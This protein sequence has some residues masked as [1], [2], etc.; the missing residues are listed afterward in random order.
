MGDD[1]R[2]RL[3]TPFHLAELRVDPAS[4]RIVGP[5][6][7]R[8]LEPRVMDVLVA[9]AARAPE[10]V[11]RA[12]LIDSVWG[13]AIV[14]DSVLSR[15][16]S[17]LREQLGDD[18]AEPRFIETLSK[19]GYRLLAPVS[20]VGAGPPAGLMAEAFARS[21]ADPVGGAAPAVAI[22]VLPFVNLAADAADEHLADGLTELMIANLAGIAS[23]RVIA[24]TSSMVYK[25]AGKRVRD[26]AA[27]LGVGYVVEGSVRREG[28][29]LQV[30]AQ[31]IEAR[32]EAHA[33]AHT[34]TREL[35]DLLTLLNEIARSVA[36][37]VSARLLPAEAARLARRVAIGERALQ[38]YLEGRYFWAQRGP[39]ALAKAI[40]AF[41]EC[42]SEAP[43]F[44]PAHVGLADSDILLAMYGIEPPRAAA[45]RA[46]EH[47]ASAMA[48]DPDGAEV[49]TA[50]GAL[51]LFFDWNH[52]DAERALVRALAQ[53]PS[54]TTAY[55]AYG[56]LLTMRG[57]FERGLGLIREGIRLS[58]FDLGLNMNL[59]DFLV[60]GRQFDAAVRQFEHTLAMDEGFVPGRVRLSE[61]LAL[62]GRGDEAMAEVA[63]AVAAAPSMPGVREAHA[64]VLATRGDRDRARS[65]LSHLVAE[66]GTRYVS[67][68]DL[69]KAY[70]VM[71]DADD[72]LRW[73][74]VAVDD[75]APMTLFAG[76]HAA[77]DPV[78]GDPRFAGII[79][80]IG[81]GR[82]CEAAPARRQAALVADRYADGRASK[83]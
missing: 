30:V 32:D 42:A 47:L 25:H 54:Y 45:E 36:K 21:S 60:F 65:E 6:G 28:S 50:L 33:W 16:V 19:K 82:S 58:P 22:A 70:A 44:A 83:R 29:R 49:Q 75:R 57:E 40:A 13:D 71:G 20:F 4:L 37:A 31:L 78:R 8:R 35:R 12:E 66:R 14:T 27:E 48:L 74:R 41:R 51:S 10:P 62:A 15:S 18:R 38:H 2:A 76:V 72:A 1:L 56:D 69:A 80:A 43:D 79:D 59:G 73:L 17:I 67:A 68:W 64:L 23:L 26:I 9:L 52:A 63:R 7:T 34:Y 46:R 3:T 24:R 11:T 61:A 5:F 77:L 39:G 55:L 53:N 81:L